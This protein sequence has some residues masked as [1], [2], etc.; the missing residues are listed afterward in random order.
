[1]D[2]KEGR[3][4][5]L[6]TCPDLGE[7]LEAG[8]TKRSEWVAEL[9]LI[10]FWTLG[11]VTPLQCLLIGETSDNN[12][13]HRCSVIAAVIGNQKISGLPMA[14]IPVWALP[15]I[16]CNIESPNPNMFTNGS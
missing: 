5:L 4:T 12:Q 2:K 6:E 9:G 8:V 7:S 15:L 13:C 3:I 14:L 10:T 16:W 11:W 1:M